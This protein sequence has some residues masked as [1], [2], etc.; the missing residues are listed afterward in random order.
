H[1]AVL[2]NFGRDLRGVAQTCIAL[3]AFL[4]SLALFDYAYNRT[5]DLLPAF[6]ARCEEALPAPAES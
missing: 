3:E 4:G 2:T 1:E 6:V 5:A